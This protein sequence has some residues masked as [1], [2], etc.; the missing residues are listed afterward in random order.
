MKQ[1]VI[2]FLVL[3]AILAAGVFTFWYVRPNTTIQLFIGIVT[4][5]LYVLW[6]LT[7]HALKKDL[8]PKVMVEYLLIG[9]I[10]IVLLVTMLGF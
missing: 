9:V 1:S 6:G 5:V 7:H 2:H 3:L 8:H 10:A 4:A